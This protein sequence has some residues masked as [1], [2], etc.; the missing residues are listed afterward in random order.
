MIRLFLIEDL[1]LTRNAIVSLF[2]KISDIKVIGA[3]RSGEEGVAAVKKEKPD[4]VLM[5]IRL[6]GING[7]EAGKKILGVCSEVKLLALTSYIDGIYPIRLIRAGFNGYLTKGC[8]ED[9]LVNAVRRVHSGQ[10][11][12]AQKV[13]QAMV[14]QSFASQ[15]ESVFDILSERELEVV[16]MIVAGMSADEIAERLFLSPKTVNCYRHRLCKKMGAG[17]D[18]ELTHLAMRYGLID[19]PMRLEA[20]EW[21]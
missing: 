20:E 13:A 10:K 5:D 9:E 7:L 6:P 1:Q 8:S 11:Y 14:T 16:S 17:N 18:V 15:G 3:V 21:V 19:Q 2:Q 12:I 4:V